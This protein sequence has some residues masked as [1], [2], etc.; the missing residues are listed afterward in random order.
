MWIED[1]IDITGS[2]ICPHCGDE[3]GLN[4]RV[5][6]ENHWCPVC[7][8]IVTLEELQDVIDKVSL[9]WVPD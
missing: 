3:I 9:I 5:L 8:H 1:H 4:S 7:L 2:I 6:W